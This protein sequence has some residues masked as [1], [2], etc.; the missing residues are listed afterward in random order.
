MADESVQGVRLGVDGEK[1]RTAKE[2]DGGMKKVF[3]VGTTVSGRP[4][5]RSVRE[6]LPHTAP[7]LGFTQ[8][9]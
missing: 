3:A 5:H 4:P 8:S 7:T 9:L 2:G 6:E 1:E